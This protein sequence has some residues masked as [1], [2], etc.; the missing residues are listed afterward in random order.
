MS[1]DYYA[2]LGVS[3][4]A[5]ADEL[6]R[7]YRKLAVQNHPDKHPDE[8]EKYEAKF[9]EINEAYA[10]LSDPQK[11][12]QYDQFGSAD[13]AS[14]GGSGFGGFGGFSGFSSSSGFGGFDFGNINDIFN[15]FFNEGNTG[16]GRRSA[17]DMEAENR[18]S[19]LKYKMD[20][21]LEEAF[22]GVKKFAE[23]N[24]LGKCSHCGGSGSADGRNARTQCSRCKGSGAVRTQQG[25][26]IVEQECPECNG[27]GVIISNPCKYCNGD[28]VEKTRKKVEV[29]IPLGVSH[30][31]TIRI[32]G[33]GEC[34][35][36]GGQ[37]GD[38]YV[39]FQIKPH[40]IFAKNGSNLECTVPIRF[41]QAALGAEITIKGIDKRDIKFMVNAGIQ[42]GEQVV[43]RG[44]GMTM[45]N[46]RRGDMIITIQVETPVKLTTEQKE[47][48]RKFDE[49]CGASSSPKSESFFDNVKKFFS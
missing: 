20:I 34:G 14:A 7:A 18:G 29:Q 43:V 28:G 32:A 19:D 11:R 41:T 22:A 8:K 6:K 3:K 10:V 44:E 40:S 48:L 9:K 35:T 23:Y 37:T 12:Q 25:F 17:R 5:S 33:E 1:K 45:R 16:G 39:V 27:E 38:L 15:S 42:S 36:H 47:L 13:G 46:G 30:G 49:S 4:D 31:D 21:T 2:I 26:F 24:T